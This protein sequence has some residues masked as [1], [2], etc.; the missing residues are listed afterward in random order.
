MSHDIRDFG[1]VEMDNYIEVADGHFITEKKKGEVQ[2]KI[3]DNDDKPFISMLFNVLFD[4]KL[5]N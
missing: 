5:C 3:C 1:L 4:P 2:I